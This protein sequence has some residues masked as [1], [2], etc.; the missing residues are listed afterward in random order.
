MEGWNISELKGFWGIKYP[1]SIDGEKGN[2][3]YRGRRNEGT[4][5]CSRIVK[6]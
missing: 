5:A 1:D 3:C 4:V 6:V 2:K